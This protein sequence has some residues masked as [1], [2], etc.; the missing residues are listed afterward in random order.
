MLHYYITLHWD[1][2]EKMQ[3]TSVTLQNW[4][5][6]QKIKDRRPNNLKAQ[7]ESRTRKKFREERRLRKRAWHWQP[8]R[9]STYIMQSFCRRR[10][11]IC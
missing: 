10:L 11:Y 9:R 7:T 8:K 1:Y 4:F 2:S 6:F 3:S 5:R